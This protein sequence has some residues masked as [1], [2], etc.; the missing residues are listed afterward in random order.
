MGALSFHPDL[1]GITSS[2]V[3]GI[4]S[5]VAHAI[6]SGITSLTA[7]AIGGVTHAAVATTEVNLHSWFQGPWRAMLTVASLAALPLLLAGVLESLA[8]GE[9]VGGL[10]RVLGRLALAGVGSLIALALVQLLL[11]LVDVSCQVVEHTSGI[12]ISGAL[13]RLGTA[14]GVTTAVGGG[15]VAAAGALL[16]ALLA[17]LAALVLWLELAMRTVLI[18]VATAFL[19]LGL[20]GL[21]WPKTASWLRRL[22]EI[23][24][25]IAISKL[26]IVVVL[27]L[28]AAALTT[29]AVSLATPGSDIDAMVNGVAFLGLA[30]LG[31]PIALRVVPFAAEAALSP[32]RG[33]VLVRS[34]YAASRLTS[35]ASST[36]TLLRRV[37]GTGT[38][39]RGDNPGG[40]P[41]T[42]G[43]SGPRPTPPS[44]GPRPAGPSR[45]NQGSDNS[46]SN[47]PP[48][49]GCGRRPSSSQ[50]A[51]PGDAS[52]PAPST[53]G[54]APS[55]TTRPRRIPPTQAPPTG[56]V[57]PSPN[58]PS[59][60]PRSTR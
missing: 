26:V 10:G 3:S 47:G 21:L 19:P 44:G 48:G 55:P 49:S 15:A 46:A 33:G 4:L 42:P 40:A 30:T 16:L 1:A 7:W 25:A 58:A 29:S 17:A 35:G 60:P 24:T 13:A 8:H 38:S 32:G 2:V 45:K 28:G 5:A 27:V 36:S 18:L 22:G 31:L 52:A 14:L 54:Q 39:G 20:S 6:G 51:A 50:Q 9:G 53:G 56:T 11:G 57:P 34:G 59:M 41:G 12:S 23:L 43:P 37:A